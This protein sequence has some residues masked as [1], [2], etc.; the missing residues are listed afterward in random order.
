MSRTLE[1]FEAAA[2]LRA[3]LDGG[4]LW[5]TMGG[6]ESTGSMIRNAFEELGDLFDTVAMSDEVR[7]VV[8]RGGGSRFS[9][10][11]DVRRMAERAGAEEPEDR[12]SH[13]SNVRFLTRMYRNLLFVDQPV[14]ACV[15]GDAVGAGATLALHCDIVVAA[16]GARL[17]D[18]HVLRGLV[19]SAGPYVWTLHTGLNTAKEYLLTGD[20]MTADEAWRVGLV[21]HVYEPDDLDAATA[22]LAQK[23]ARGAPRAIQLTKRVLNRMAMRQHVDLLEEGIAQELLTFGTEDHAEGARSFLERRP[24]E[25]RGR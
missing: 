7:V 16:R 15:N 2:T 19:A 14:V 5:V 21:N 12:L 4:I 20:L 11:G 8:L 24:P 9:T 6:P 3:V 13:R 1:E 22:E 17:G 23:L 25:F 18:P 10:G